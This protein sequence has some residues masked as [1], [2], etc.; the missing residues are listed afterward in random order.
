MLRGAANGALT[1]DNATHAGSAT[2]AGNANTVGGVT[3]EGF[4]YQTPSNGAEATLFSVGGLT[5]KAECFSG[6]VFATTSVNGAYISAVWISGTNAS[7]RVT[8][9]NFKT[10]DN[11]VVNS[12]TGAETGSIEY[13]QPNGTSVSVI[14]QSDMAVACTVSGHVFAG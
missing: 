10:T 9:T 1:A 11:L 14:L 12:T 8:N 2:S 7:A 6:N 13:V 4:H 3:V 5:L